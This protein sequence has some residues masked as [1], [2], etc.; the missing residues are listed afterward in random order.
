MATG[1]APRSVAG[2]LNPPKIADLLAQHALAVE[3][4]LRRAREW[5]KTS[6][7][8]E[9]LASL[10]ATTLVDEI[11]VLR[12]VLSAKK[13][14]VEEALA[15]LLATLRWRVDNASELI[16]IRDGEVEKAA[17]LGTVHKYN[18]VGNVG[19]LNDMHPLMVVRVGL[20]RSHELM[21]T[22]S[23]DQVSSS[24]LIQNEVIFR[25][26]DERTRKLG[27]LCK[28]VGI[29]DMQGASLRNFDRRFAKALGASSHA[30][31]MYYPQLLGRMVLINIP[32]LLRMAIQAF[33]LFMSEKTRE[34]QTVCP[35]THTAKKDAGDCPFLR[36]FNPPGKTQVPAFL[37][38]T[39][40][41]PRALLPTRAEDGDDETRE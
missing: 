26:T 15:A 37:G 24:L 4:V 19:F 14:D 10:E 5:I 8:T 17:W 29:I 25:M 1:D 20:N 22:L 40:P 11:F 31:A 41:T 33:T 36:A 6:L 39:Y 35:A 27:V 18:K 28:G 3:S 2:L 9:Q 12:F 34:K 30:S 7:T 23:A 32:F 13:S 16:K 38:G 21:D